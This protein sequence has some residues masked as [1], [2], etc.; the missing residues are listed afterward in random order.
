MCHSTAE[1]CRALDDDDAD[2]VN[3]IVLFFA[4]S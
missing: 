4:K 3:I 1:A 2:D